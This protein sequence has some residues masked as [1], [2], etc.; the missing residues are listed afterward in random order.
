MLGQFLSC[1]HRVPAKE[2]VVFDSWHRYLSDELHRFMLCIS[3][4]SVIR[5]CRTTCLSND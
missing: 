1:E 5:C 4:M 2:R 3:R